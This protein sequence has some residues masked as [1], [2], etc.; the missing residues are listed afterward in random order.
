MG[1]DLNRGHEMKDIVREIPFWL[2]S[3]AGAIALLSLQAMLDAPKT[4][5]GCQMVA[6][7]APQG[8]RTTSYRAECKPAKPRLPA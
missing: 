8:F 3:A 1:K 2:L 7:P 5:T 6:S 4:E